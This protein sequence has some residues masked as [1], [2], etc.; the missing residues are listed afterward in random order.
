MI[1]CLASLGVRVLLVLTLAA[2][3]G[4]SDAAP[5][6]ENLT[7]FWQL[8]LTPTGSTTE[9]GPSAIYLSQTDAMISAAG[10]TGS[11]SGASFTLTVDSGGIVAQF[12]GTATPTSAAGTV[13]LTSLIT[14]TATFRLERFTPVGTFDVSGTI[15]GVAVDLTGAGYGSLDYVDEALTQLGEVEIGAAD[16]DAQLEIAFSPTGLVVGALGVPDDITA[17]VLYRTGSTVTESTCA[18][19]VTITQYDGSGIAGSF[20]LTLDAGGTITGT[21]EVSFDLESYDP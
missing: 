14:V 19:S 17:V 20:T 9:Q 3:G 6:T 16:V 11:M 8:Y 7:G 1:R 10:A 18:G 21:F 13:T 15:D 2:C 5:P 4:G 12:N